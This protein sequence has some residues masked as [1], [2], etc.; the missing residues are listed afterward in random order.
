[1]LQ[2]TPILLAV[3][4]GLFMYRF[5]VW[6]TQ[7][8]LAKQSTPLDD[9]KLI[10]A[11][12]PMAKALDVPQIKVNVYHIDAV[13]GLATADGKIFITDGFLRKYKIG[14]VSEA[15]L[16]SVVAHELGHVA[17]GHTR[18]RMI[19]FSG[20]NAMRTAL[21]MILG[22]VL[23]GI[24]PWVA[25]MVANLMAAKLSRSDEFEADAY[26]TALMIKAGYGAKPQI[27]LF[28]KL[29]NLTGANGSAMPAWFLSH[30]K[31]EE[32][33]KAIEHNAARWQV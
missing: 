3:L 31:T 12:T 7:S 19:D 5:S 29:D 2:L 30:P 9:P 26:A 23:P 10:D 32:R 4:Y 14:E 27:D 22:R 13:N 6:R 1:M 24:G 18:K 17:L 21:A 25:G 8:A 15:E 20:Q 33:I 11:L 16:A 28:T